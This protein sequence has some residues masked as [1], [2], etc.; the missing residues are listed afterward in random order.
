MRTKISSF[1]PRVLS[2]RTELP[3]RKLASAST[4]SHLAHDSVT[5]RSQ[6]PV[7]M[8]LYRHRQPLVS[9][10]HPLPHFTAASLLLHRA[11]PDKGDV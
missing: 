1:Y 2:L 7:Q 9:L 6:E 11:T 10:N 3:D 8:Y 5:G 4:P